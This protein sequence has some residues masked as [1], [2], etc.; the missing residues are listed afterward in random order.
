MKKL[1][2]AVISV[3]FLAGFASAQQQAQRKSPSS[4]ASS[5]SRSQNASPHPMTAEEAFFYFAT[6]FGPGGNIA[7]RYASYFDAANYKQAMANEFSRARYQEKMQAKVEAELK[8]IDFN[9]EFTITGQAGLGEYSFASHSFPVSGG[10]VVLFCMDAAR[11]FFG[12][13]QG[14]ILH[15][16]AFAEQNAVNAADFDWLLTMPEAE[17]SAFL[18]SRT[19][20]VNGGVNR[21]V[22]TKITYSIIGVR[23]RT[24]GV[25]GLPATFKPYIH[26]VEVYSDGSLTRQLGTLTKRP[27]IP[28]SAYAPEVAQA[29]RSTTNVIGTYRHRPFCRGGYKCVTPIEETI[30]V[31]DAG[32]AFS[33]EQPDGSTKP[34]EYSYFD[35]FAEGSTELWRADWADADYY[36]VWRPFWQQYFNSSLIFDNRPERDHFFVDLTQAIQQW[37]VKYPQFAANEL[38]IYEGCDRNGGGFVTC[39][40]TALVN[41]NADSTRSSVRQ[42]TPQPEGRFAP[43]MN[44]GVTRTDSGN[45][46]HFIVD[47]TMPGFPTSWSSSNRFNLIEIYG[48]QQQANRTVESTTYKISPITGNWMPGDAARIEFDVP[49]EYTDPSQGWILAFC[50]HA[51]NEVGCLPSSN[52]LKERAD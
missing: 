47:F 1:A 8:R 19:T 29:A 38:K 32:I 25:G 28:E 16:E 21:A 14:S 35:A 26:T 40:D 17:A 6:I 7:D 31:T 37:K 9:R 27:G 46:Y 45:K 42:Y 30:T 10:G 41:A 43:Q 49:K 44:I 15:V 36:V 5:P 22:F 3:A 20:G 48:F 24:E 23:G 4:A 11:T 33:G 52:L 13:C 50:L 51:S 39:P 2:L 34:R 18:K 12:N